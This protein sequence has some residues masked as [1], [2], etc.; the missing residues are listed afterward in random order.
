MTKYGQYCPTA[1][2]AEILGDRWTFKER[3]HA[4]C[5]SGSFRPCRNNPIAIFAAPL[6]IHIWAAVNEQPGGFRAT[7]EQGGVQRREPEA[8]AARPRGCPR[9]DDRSTA[10]SRRRCGV[11]GR[12]GRTPCGSPLMRISPGLR[13]FC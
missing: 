13:R 6:Q 7:S 10:G 11:H 3:F 5:P 4:S 12:H 2:A 1:R 9:H 8:D